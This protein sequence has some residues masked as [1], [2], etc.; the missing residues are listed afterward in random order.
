M[1][2]A[3]ES[4]TVVLGRM[5]YVGKHDQQRRSRDR[6]SRDG[7]Y[8][9]LPMGLASQAFFIVFKERDNLRF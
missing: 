5:P 6:I 8:Q 4:H 9:N 1:H 3:W 7:T 2:Y